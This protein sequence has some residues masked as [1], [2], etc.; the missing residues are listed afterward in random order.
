MAT[1]TSS[2]ES[3]TEVKKVTPT[4]GGKNS[5]WR[6]TA[7]V[8]VLRIAVIALCLVLW[9]VMS[10]PVLPEYAVSKPTDVS[11]ALWDLLGS[12]TGWNDIRAT[13]VEIV[14]GFGI[15]VAIGTVMGLVLGSVPLAGQVLEPLIAA[16]N[17]IPK[18]ALAPLFL[19]FFGIG[20]MSK[21]TIAA[22]G[23]AFV[24][25]YNVYLGLR[26]RERELVEIVQVMGGRRHHVL[27]YVTLPT[28]AAPFFAAL[29]TGG[30][31][32][33]LGVIGGEFIAST[34]GVGHELFT[35][36]TNLDA[37]TEF[38]GLIVLVAMT[39]ILNGVL[40]ALDTL[41]LKRLGLGDR[42]SGRKIT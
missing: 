41:A 6:R 18:I 33:I 22:A 24:V 11:H 12:S 29:K 28:L 30:P 4:G 40:T 10:G 14:A 32:A 20:P 19:L 39:L 27:S 9:Q 1:A 42:R 26:L 16:V 35:A 25:F 38:A 37:P 17:G 3:K 15:G 36:A 21:I 23:V 8:V 13:A 7:L 34:E 2:A 5:V 31:L